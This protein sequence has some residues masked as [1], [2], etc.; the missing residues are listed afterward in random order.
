MSPFLSP[1]LPSP[2]FRSADRQRGLQ[3]AWLTGKEDWNSAQR[4]QGCRTWAFF[5]GWCLSTWRAQSQGPQ[6]SS[7]KNTIKRRARNSQRSAFGICLLPFCRRNRE[8][9]QIKGVLIMSETPRET[10]SQ[11]QRS[12]RQLSTSETSDDEDRRPP[13]ADP[14]LLM[15]IKMHRHTAQLRVAWRGVSAPSSVTAAVC[16]SH[17]PELLSKELGDR[18]A[19]TSSR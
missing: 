4:A 9:R 10:Q 11:S 14:H 19:W 7:A 2:V 6:T 3:R 15:A 1:S 18:E 17:G 5:F 12:K 16:S 13:G 8:S